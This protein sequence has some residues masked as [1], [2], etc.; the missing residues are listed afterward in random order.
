MPQ[1]EYFNYSIEDVEDLYS[2]VTDVLEDLDVHVEESRGNI[3]ISEKYGHRSVPGF[4]V[5]EISELE[6]LPSSIS[7]NLHEQGI[8]IVYDNLDLDGEFYVRSI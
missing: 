1:K 2:A 3:L 6:E 8:Q 7:Y 5:E 4:T